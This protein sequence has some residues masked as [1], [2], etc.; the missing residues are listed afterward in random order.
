VNTRERGARTDPKDSGEASSLVG[1]ISK[2]Q[3]GSRAERAKPPERAGA[4]KAESG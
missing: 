4:K 1:K 3:M 2:D